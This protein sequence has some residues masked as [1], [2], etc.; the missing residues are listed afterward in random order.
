[1]KSLDLG[2]DVDKGE[3]LFLTATSMGTTRWELALEE[4]KKVQ[5]L[6][7]QPW[8]VTA[9][10]V[11][12]GG[13]GEEGQEQGKGGA[14]KQA[15]VAKIVQRARFLKQPGKSVMVSFTARDGLI[16]E[17]TAAME[18]GQVVAGIGMRRVWE[19]V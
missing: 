11:L 12:G 13:A 19:R 8:E 1:M 17:E 7:F 18:E 10:I 2:F 9:S 15:P 5:G 3:L 14:E 6:D 4:A 16:F